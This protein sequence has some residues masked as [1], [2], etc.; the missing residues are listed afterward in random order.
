MTLDYSEIASAVEQAGLDPA[1]VIVASYNGRWMGGDTCFG[2]K[3]DMLGDA[4]DI[5]LYLNEAGINAHDLADRVAE[6]QLGTNSLFYFPGYKLDNAPD[7]EEDED[8]E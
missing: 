3:V 7:N 2:L 4:F 1:E 8:D 6:D 5:L